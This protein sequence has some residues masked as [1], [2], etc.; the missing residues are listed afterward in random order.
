VVQHKAFALVSA[1]QPEVYNVGPWQGIMPSVS[2]S[3]YLS[4]LTVTCGMDPVAL[5]LLLN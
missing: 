4:L 1:F 2:V 5:P 3:W